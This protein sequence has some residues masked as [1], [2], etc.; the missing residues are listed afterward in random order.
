[1]TPTP[2]PTYDTADVYDV[3]KKMA[4]VFREL[5]DPTTKLPFVYDA[6]PNSVSAAGM[7]CIITLPGAN[8]VDDQTEGDEDTSTTIYETR[9]WDTLL[10]AAPLGAN[11]PGEAYQAALKLISPVRDLVVSYPGLKGS[12]M[13]QWRFLGDS[14]VKADIIYGGQPY[15]GIRFQTETR[16]LVKVKYAE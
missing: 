12:A 8:T 13:L 16:N 3:L 7:P 6:P 10:L 2:P 14:G 15:Y 4:I 5:T 9:K 1:M 11:Y